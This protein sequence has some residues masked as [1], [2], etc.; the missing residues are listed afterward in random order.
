MCNTKTKVVEM[1]KCG[2]HCYFR[3]C[4]KCVT[5]PKKHVYYIS[6]TRRVDI[7]TG[8]DVDVYCNK[9]NKEIPEDDVNFLFC[10][11]ES[12]NDGPKFHRFQCSSCS[13]HK[14]RDNHGIDIVSRKIEH[15]QEHRNLL[16]KGGILS[17]HIIAENKTIEKRKFG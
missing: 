8:D 10:L 17:A 15:Q 9:C 2:K 12:F 7:E 13:R 4:R 11:D 3:S 5:C 6:K 1:Y 16:K 14:Y